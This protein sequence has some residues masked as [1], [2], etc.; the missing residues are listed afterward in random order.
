M[1]I[2]RTKLRWRTLDLESCEG[3][4]DKTRKAPFWKLTLLSCQ[5]LWLPLLHW[6][7]SIYGRSACPICFGTF[8]G[9]SVI[10]VTKRGLYC[11]VR[12][13]LSLSLS[14][15]LWLMT[16]HCLVIRVKKERSDIMAIFFFFCYRN[17]QGFFVFLAAIRWTKFHR[18]NAR[19]AYNLQCCTYI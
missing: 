7:W 5:V 13:N 12:N 10:N 18:R 14:H 17:L 11:V 3:S 2:M 8:A 1:H 19:H 6:L 9:Q 4:I 15:F 16:V